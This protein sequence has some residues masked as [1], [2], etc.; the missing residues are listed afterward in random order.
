M[1]TKT[2]R[3]LH[4]PLPDLMYTQ[5]RKEAQRSN[6]PATD[7]AREAID[8]WLVEQQR[9]LVHESVAEYARCAA[10]S[11]EDLD[12]QLEAAAIDELLTFDAPSADRPNE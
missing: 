10:G 4:V 9:R 12:E 1:P 5:L 6:R 8:R 7:I 11:P 3:N 2:T